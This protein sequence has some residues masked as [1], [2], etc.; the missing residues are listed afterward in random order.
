MRPGGWYAPMNQGADTIAADATWADDSAWPLSDTDPERLVRKAV[1]L[2]TLVIT[3][4]RQHGLR[5]NLKPGKSVIMINL[6]GRGSYK[7]RAKH[8]PAKGQQLRL[9]DLDV[10]VPIVNQ[11]RHL[12]G[13]VD[14]ASKLAVEAR[15]RTAMAG[16]AYD[17]GK[18]IF[19]AN[20]RIALPTKVALFQAVIDPIYFNLGLWLTEDKSWRILSEGYTRIL[21]R[22]LVRTWG[23]DDAFH[24]PLP[25]VHLT[26]AT[27]PL[28][29]LLKRARLSLLCSIAKAEA[30]PLWAMLQNEQSWYRAVRDDIRWVIVGTEDKWPSLGEASWPEWAAL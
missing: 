18:K 24:V 29:L 8:F 12:G 16:S 7:T 27:P 26:T 3:F 28:D 19:F 30:A 14:G 2:S 4:C 6:R 13:I 22:L 23:G 20:P 17:A 11:Y 10:A 15:R 9:P 21:R 5:P 1:R 25:A